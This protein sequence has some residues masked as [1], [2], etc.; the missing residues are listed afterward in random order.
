M[1]MEGVVSDNEGGSGV[2]EVVYQTS[3]DG[4]TWGDEE[5]FIGTSTWKGTVSDAVSKTTRIKITARDNAGNEISETVGPWN[6]DIN[7]PSLTQVKE[8]DKVLS[9]AEAYYSNG[10]SDIVLKITA[11]D[12]SGES[13]VG[14]RPETDRGPERKAKRRILKN[15]HKLFS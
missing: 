8:G 9:E 12:G 3:T 10:G 15:D 13:G 4:N 11:A 7:P 5:P 6:I 2:S 14:W 1:K